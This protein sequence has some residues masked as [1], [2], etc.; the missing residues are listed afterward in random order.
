MV[1]KMYSLSLPSGTCSPLSFLIV[2]IE[3]IY[4]FLGLL[5]YLFDFLLM[6]WLVMC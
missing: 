3:F 2:L 1:L 6:L 4:Y 5:V